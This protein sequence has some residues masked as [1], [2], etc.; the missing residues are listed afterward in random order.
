[1]KDKLFS[2]DQLIPRKSATIEM[3]KVRPKPI[4]LTLKIEDPV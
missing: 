4:D 2:G 3:N 1:M